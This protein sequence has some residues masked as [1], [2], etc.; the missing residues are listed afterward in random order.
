MGP[1]KK[2]GFNRNV[3]RFISLYPGNWAISLRT[4]LRFTHTSSET[5][6]M[7]LI[8][9]PSVIS[10]TLL[11]MTPEGLNDWHPGLVNSTSMSWP[12]YSPQSPK[13]HYKFRE[14]WVLSCSWD[15]RC[16]L[17]KIPYGTKQ[18]IAFSIEK[19]QFF[20]RQNSRGNLCHLQAAGFSW[21]ARH[22]PCGPCVLSHC[23][24]PGTGTPWS[25]YPHLPGHTGC[26]FISHT[27]AE[28]NYPSA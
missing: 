26:V 24:L 28:D 14:Q 23:V 22:R 11:T 15:A 13:M 20:R 3:G 6:A 10:K 1:Q 12:C 25:Q 7:V 5:H 19:I 9:H 18:K 27:A 4:S 8:L 17:Q 21:R 2:K 16:Q